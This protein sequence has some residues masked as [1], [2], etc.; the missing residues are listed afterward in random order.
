MSATLGP[1]IGREPAQ[2]TITYTEN[3]DGWFTAQIVEFPGAISQGPTRHDAWVNVLEALHDLTHVPTPAE[4]VA[5]A[6]QARII[7]PLKELLHRLGRHGGRPR[8]VV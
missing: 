1:E 7:E 8:P 4:T 5:F 6:V 2:L 3:D